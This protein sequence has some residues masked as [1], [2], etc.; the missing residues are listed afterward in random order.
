MKT[1]PR[2][3]S[4]TSP[5]VSKNGAV[6]SLNPTDDPLPPWPE[7]DADGNYPAMEF[8]TVSIAREIKQRRLDAG[9]TQAELAKLARVRRTTLERLERAEHMPGIASIEKLDRALPELSPE[10]RARTESRSLQP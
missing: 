2:T 9:L 6:G 3:R 10:A 4:N 7:P 5:I 8:I 1:R